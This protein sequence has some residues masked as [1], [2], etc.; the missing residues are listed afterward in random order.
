MF[1]PGEAQS[2]EDVHNRKV[3]GMLPSRDPGSSRNYA[4][5]F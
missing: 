1:F 2:E 5:R 4:T 3:G